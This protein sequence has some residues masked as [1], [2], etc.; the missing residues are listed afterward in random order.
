MDYIIP[1]CGSGAIK[2]TEVPGEALLNP[3]LSEI[4]TW[5]W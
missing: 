1:D 4:L 2:V 5:L 3:S